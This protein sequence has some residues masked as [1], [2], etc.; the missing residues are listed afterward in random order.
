MDPNM[1]AV[2]DAM[3]QQQKH[4]MQQQQEHFMTTLKTL[5]NP[6]MR[7]TVRSSMP[8]SDTFDKSKENWAQYIE[9]LNQNFVLH[10]VTDL[11][12]KRV[13]LL[14]SLDLEMYKLLQNLF[15]ELNISEQTFTDLVEKLSNHFKQAIHVQAS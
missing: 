14:S 7:S 5:F 9:R 15:E 6:E 11:D 3:Q 8:R 10:N 13:F 4:F 12:K 1:Q 2:I